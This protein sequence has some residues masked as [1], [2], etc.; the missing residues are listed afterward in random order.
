[1][2]LLVST[3]TGLRQTGTNTFTG[4]QQK[5]VQPNRYVYEWSTGKWRKMEPDW[6]PEPNK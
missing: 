6:K 2:L 5:V 1:M 3:S 4:Q